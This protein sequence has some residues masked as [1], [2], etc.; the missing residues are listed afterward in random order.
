MYCFHDLVPSIYYLIQK[1][2]CFSGLVTVRYYLIQKTINTN[3][4][5]GNVQGAC[6]RKRR[7]YLI[8][9]YIVFMVLAQGACARASADITEKTR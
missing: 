1:F 5:H 9:K 6:A 3:S 7:Y 2:N 8:Q 4:F